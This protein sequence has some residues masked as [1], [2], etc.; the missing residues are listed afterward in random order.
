MGDRVSGQ[1]F[2][3]SLLI[4]VLI[5]ISVFVPKRMFSSTASLLWQIWFYLIMG[6]R[7][8]ENALH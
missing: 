8:E 6:P 7:W 1:F 2:S 4:P 5:R 3:G